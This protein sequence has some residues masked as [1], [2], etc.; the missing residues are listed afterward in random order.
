MISVEH[1]SA[2]GPALKELRWHARMKQVEVCRATGMT[3]PQV[4]RYENG[5]E[6]PTV[7]SLVRYLNAVEADLCDLQ[8]VLV[9]G[10]IPI[11]GPLPK[12]ELQV[13]AKPVDEGPS[14]VGQVLDDA[15]Q[16]LGSSAALQDIVSGLV[17]LNLEG[18]ERMENRM[19]SMEES[20]ADLKRARPR[21]P[22]GR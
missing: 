17:K 1:L 5:R 12:R 4:S 13:P 15:G 11:H 7:E 10:Q 6:M 16:R 8:Q 9:T 20:M 21:P 14:A 22:S 19:R 18:M 3:A 2:M